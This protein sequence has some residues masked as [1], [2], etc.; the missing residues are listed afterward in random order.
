MNIGEV[1]N[2]K[3][4]QV[5]DFEDKEV[6]AKTYEADMF[7]EFLEKYLKMCERGASEKERYNLAVEN[8]FLSEK[9]LSLWL[10]VNDDFENE[11]EMLESEKEFLSPKEIKKREAKVQELEHYANNIKNPTY[12][13]IVMRQIGAKDYSPYGVNVLRGKTFLDEEARS[14]DVDRYLDTYGFLCK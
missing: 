2:S 3:G 1:L 12:Y 7:I 11:R 5:E 9:H 14:I 10:S 13:R 8:G 4:I 6:D